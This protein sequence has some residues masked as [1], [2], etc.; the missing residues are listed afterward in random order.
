MIVRACLVAVFVCAAAGTTQA[1]QL[2]PLTQNT[3]CLDASAE[4]G[5]R[6]RGISLQACNDG[7]DQDFRR[8]REHTISV[9][10][11]CLQAITL[12]DSP[13]IQLVAAPCHGGSG[14]RWALTRDGRLTPGERMCLTKTG[15]GAEARLSMTQC[16][17]EGED[18][19]DQKWAL[20]GKFE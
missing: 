13:E 16:K 3:V 20:Y 10:Q 7:P 17:A 14:Q 8:G 5:Q 11:L 4:I 18:M 1:A 9:G 2:R 19:A 6:L 12:G 15:E